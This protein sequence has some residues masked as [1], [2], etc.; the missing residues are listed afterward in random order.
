MAHYSYDTTFSMG[1]HYL[2]ALD[3]SSRCCKILSKNYY[4]LFSER[5]IEIK[6]YDLNDGNFWVIFDIK[7]SDFAYLAGENE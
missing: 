2:A 7:V 4:L 5:K 1:K 3:N 6:A